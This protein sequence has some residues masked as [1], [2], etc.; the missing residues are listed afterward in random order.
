MRPRW[1]ALFFWL[2][3]ALLG[4]LCWVFPSKPVHIGSLSL[5]WA[6]LASV[7]DMEKPSPAP[8]YGDTLSLYAEADALSLPPD[9][10]LAG[11][12]VPVAEVVPPSTTAADTL[13]DTR[14]YLASFYASLSQT[15]SRTVRVVHYGDSQIEEDRMTQTIRRALQARFGGGGVGLVPLLQTIPTRTLHQMLLMD[16]RAVSIQQG[17]P[18]RLVYGP[19][20]MR[21]ADGRYGV[22]GQAALM[23]DSLLRGSEHLSVVLEPMSK[24]RNTESYF[25]RLRV[26]ADDEVALVSTVGDTLSATETLV[27][28]DSTTHYTFSLFGRGQVYGVSLETPTGIVVDN[29]PMRG[30]IGTVFRSIDSVQLSTFYQ[31]TNTRLIILQFGGN[32]IPFNEQPSTIR[33]IVGQLAQQVRYLRACAPEANILFVGPG[34]MATLIDGQPTTYPLLPYMDKLLAEMATKEQVAYYSLY[35]AMGGKNSMLEWQK[36]GWAGA[37]GVHFTRKGAEKAGKALAEWL[38]DIPAESA[39]VQ[40]E[41]VPVDTLADKEELFVSS[42]SAD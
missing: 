25:S 22:M 14:K 17:I 19:K 37:D 15:S 3:I 39:T 34:D 1:I 29:I 2:C 28:P 41:R 30:C 23:N 18:R 38:L 36:H 42:L 27:L 26:W 32:A 31:E 11:N 7:L 16:G 20:S 10:T 8:V 40:A 35:S 5:R 24:E 6:A 12:T 21:S 13:Q 4:V 9:S 33:G